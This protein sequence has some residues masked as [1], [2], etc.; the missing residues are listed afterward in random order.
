VPG[1]EVA[2][3]VDRGASS[4]IA[5]VFTVRGKQL[6]R[7]SVRGF[8]PDRDRLLLFLAAGMSFGGADCLRG[9]SG[10]IMQWT[11]G[12]LPQGYHLSEVRFRAVGLAF[13]PVARREVDVA[14][15]PHLGTGFASCPRRES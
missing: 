9:R 4:A 11:A 14:R 1:A 2:V 6:R 5:E 8:G 7:M 13:R 10:E 3:V 15:P 12:R